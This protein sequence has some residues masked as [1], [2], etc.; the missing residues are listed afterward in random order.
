MNH[1]V[2]LRDVQVRVADQRIIHCVP[3]SLFH[4]TNPSLMVIHGVNAQS[5]DLST[6]FVELWFQAGQVAK[7]GRADGREVLRVREQD[8]PFVSDPFVKSNRPFSAFG[9]E[10]GCFLAYADSHVKPPLL[11]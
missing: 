11:A 6:T 7:L 2:E 4:I 9:R 1:V 3:L 10:I 5:N 8:G